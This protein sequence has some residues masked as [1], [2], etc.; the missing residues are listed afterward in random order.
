MDLMEMLNP[1]QKKA[2]S[3]TEGP[4]LVIA[5]AGSG[6]T[7]VLTRRVAYLISLKKPSFNILAIT[8]TNKAAKEMRGRIDE[9]IGNNDV[10]VS[11]FHSLCVRILRRHISEIGFDNSFT[12]YDAD[13]SLRLIKQCLKDLDVNEKQFPPKSAAYAIGAWKDALIPPELASSEFAG[14]Y[15][16]KQFADTYELYQRK[17]RLNNALD[18]DDLIFKTIDLFRASPATLQKY[19]DRFRYILVDE[20]QDTNA[21]QYHVVNLL[22]GET[23]N[24]FVV[25]DDDQSIYG[26]RGADIRNILDFQKDYENAEMIKLEQNYRSTQ[27]ILDAAN[28]VIKN[29]KR[30]RPK[31]LWTHKPG[32]SPICYFRAENERDEAAFVA[33]TI[34]SGV[35]DEGKNFSDFA[36]LYRNNAQSRAI[37]DAFMTRSVPYRIYGGVRFYERAEIKDV[38]AYLRVV[39]N[40]RDS[41]SL[42]RIINA[43]RRGVGDA[44]IDRLSLY[45]ARNDVP[46][47]EA[48][49]NL[50]DVEGLGA[51]AAKLVKFKTLMDSFITLAKSGSV[52]EVMEAI[53]DQTGYKRELLAENTPESL[54]RAENIDEFF[55]KAAD[56]ENTSGD[57]SLS[58]FLEELSLIAD[59]DGY[60]RDANVVSLMTLHSSKG[61]E[62]P[63][64]FL[65]GLE[66]GLFPSYRSVV[67]DDIN[68]VEEERRLCYVGITRAREQLF[69]SSAFSRRQ[70][71][72]VAFNS[73]S[74]FLKE[75]PE[76]LIQKMDNAN[77]FEN[78]EPSDVD[79]KKTS[80]TG[81]SQYAEINKVRNSIDISFGG[82]NYAS[83]IPAPNQKP[84]FA[85]GDS[86]R[87]MKYGVGTVKNIA[88]AGADY[89]VTVEFDGLGEKKFMSGL[90]KIKKIAK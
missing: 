77:N 23:A 31:L 33:R 46:L 79:E 49:E 73:P 12:I 21:A 30:R 41:V 45:A 35:K 32:G 68:S 42:A 18:F 88:A 70:H 86:V 34:L 51:R 26:W 90:S 13:D 9:L 62:F 5:G 55:S 58:S 75:I 64:V 10:W 81:I 22:A 14:D 2:V 40:P 8:F 6:K 19:R 27:M 48:F 56:F 66:E 72:Q 82:K 87:L 67:S 11:T 76:G 89:E 15:R 54:S 85:V 47:Y 44:T 16:Q 69:I 28:A 4:A 61:L 63:R 84:D 37:E 20:Y 7:N 29:N 50:D 80:R 3:H 65:V 24:L 74:R 36:A 43:P 57:K 60:E 71:G 53:I 83:A 59:I 52:T 17:L 38:I 78:S 1:M 25:G 39:N